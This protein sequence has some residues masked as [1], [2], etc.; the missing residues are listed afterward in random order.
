[1]DS[2]EVKNSPEGQRRVRK[3]ALAPQPAADGWLQAA[4]L[5]AA[6][7]A[8]V[9]I[10]ADR[11]IVRVNHAF[12][13]WTGFE[14]SELV[15]SGWPYP[16]WPEGEQQRGEARWHHIEHAGPGEFELT[17]RHGDGRPLDAVM[18]ASPA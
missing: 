2:D 5:D 10:G 1:M 7:A 3:R 17:V 13:D 15:G 14:V 16:Y 18:S 9:V 8:L 12:C 6:P 4:L 11:R